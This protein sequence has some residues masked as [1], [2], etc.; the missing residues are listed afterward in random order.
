MD[1]RRKGFFCWKM[2]QTMSYLAEIQEESS[3]LLHWKFSHIPTTSHQT[4]TRCLASTSVSPWVLPDLPDPE[5]NRKTSLFWNKK[6]SN[7][8]MAGLSAYWLYI[9]WSNSSKHPRH[10]TVKPNTKPPML[11]T[12]PFP[13]CNL[14]WPGA[15]WEVGLIVNKGLHLGGLL[16][17]VFGKKKL[18]VFGYI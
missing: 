10:L 11:Q 1:S 16:F 13:V 14:Q 5:A 4:A 9:N 8:K 12:K 17:F 2:T 15:G 6:T 18:M 3:W 7:G